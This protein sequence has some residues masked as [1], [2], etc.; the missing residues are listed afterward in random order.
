MTMQQ[1][2]IF[3]S[4]LNSENPSGVT[5][6]A[7]TS[8]DGYILKS[9][10]NGITWSIDST[11][12]YGNPTCFAALQNDDFVYGTDTGYMV[13]VTQG[14]QTQ[15]SEAFIYDICDFMFGDVLYVVAADAEGDY[16]GWIYNGIPTLLLSLGSPIYKIVNRGDGLSF[17]L[18]SGVGI[19][20]VSGELKQEGD[21]VA[22]LD[23][24]DGMYYAGDANDNI[25]VSEN[26][27]EDWSD[28]GQIL[29]DTATNILSMNNGRIG[30]SVIG[31]A[32]NYTDD[33]FGSVETVSLTDVL[34]D[35]DSFIYLGS[36]VALMGDGTLGK[37]LRTTD[38]GETWNDL[39]QMEEQ[40][41]INCFI[42]I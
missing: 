1:N 7:G 10:N 19:Y 16:Y 25:W 34:T 28:L 36:S 9:T 24:G 32:F 37:I 22:F 29:Y 30:V 12:E 23:K 41:S 18:I 21:F 20:D 35:A 3:N 42:A 4:L 15:V 31:D 14:T 38:N 27:G 40:V 13:N 39:G 33:N 6:Y 5:V 2:C 17:M 11:S 26:Y 8:P